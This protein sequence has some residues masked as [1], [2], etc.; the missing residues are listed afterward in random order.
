MYHHKRRCR[1]TTSPPSSHHIILPLYHLPS[2]HLNI[3]SPLAE[4]PHQTRRTHNHRPRKRLSPP[5]SPKHKPLARKVRKR[6]HI[7][8]D[9]QLVERWFVDVVSG[10]ETD[11]AGQERPCSER[12][13]G[14]P[15]DVRGLF[16]GGIDRGGVVDARSVCQSRVGL[17]GVEGG[18]ERYLR[19]G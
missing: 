6:D 3:I 11:H 2:L 1:C 7:R 5:R 4:H 13:A 18:D 16:D 19:V 8:P 17:D 9:C 12:A 15:G 14:E 10:V